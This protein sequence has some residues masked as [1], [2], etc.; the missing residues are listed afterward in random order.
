[1]LAEIQYAIGGR[2]QEPAALHYEDIDVRAGGVWLRRRLQ[3]SKRRGQRR[4]FVDGLKVDGDNGDME[5]FMP[6]KKAAL[7]CQEWAVKNGIRSGPLFLVDGQPLKYKA[8]CYRYSTAF[9]KAGMPHRGTHILRHAAITEFQESCKDIYLTKK[10]ARHKSV[11]TTE[12]Y[13]KNRDNTFRA[14]LDLMEENLKQMSVANC[15]QN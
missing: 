14:A 1:V 4:A 15:G 7:L 12:G 8:I 9:E 3:W 5:I 11:T 6:S 13:S 10:F 2:V